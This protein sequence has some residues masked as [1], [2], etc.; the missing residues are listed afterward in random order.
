MGR[1]RR[2]F[3]PGG[4]YHVFARGSNRQPIFV[5]DT[6]RVDFLA[7]LEHV[8]VRCRLRCLA[9]CLMSNHYHLIVET[10]D[11]R[12]SQAMQRLNSRYALRFNRRY[13]RDAHLFKNR[14][15]AV[16]QTTESQLLW[17]LRYVVRNPIES[18][19]CDAPEH[20]PWSSYRAYAGLERAP[21]FLDVG[22][23]LSHFGDTPERAQNVFRAYVN[24]FVGV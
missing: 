7:C 5:H 18:G 21:R 6:D 15:G 8:V 16:A 22:Q 17:T 9:Y 12:L 14:F 13:E 23:L 4:A 1:A 3:A 11:G 10:P 2:D 20:W 24:G 19:V